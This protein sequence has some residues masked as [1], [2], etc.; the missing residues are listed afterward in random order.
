M[1]AI[2]TCDACPVGDD[3]CRGIR[4]RRDCHNVATGVGGYAAMLRTLAG[5]TTPSTYLFTGGM[6]DLIVLESWMSAAARAR[7]RTALWAAPNSPAIAAMLSSIPELAHVEHVHLWSEFSATGRRAFYSMADLMSVVNDPRLAD[8]EDWSTSARFPKIRAGEYRWGGS[9][10]LKRPGP[11][12]A[13]FGLPDR[14]VAICPETTSTHRLDRWFTDADWGWVL[15]YLERTGEVGVVLNGHG[16]LRPPDHPNLIDLG[17][18]TTFLESVEVVRRCDGYLGIDSALSVIAAEVL[19]PW[20]LA[21]K[22]TVDFMHW[23]R[24]VCYPR[25]AGYVVVRPRMAAFGA[26]PRDPLAS[27]RWE[28]GADARLEYCPA[29]GVA[30]L[31]DA[32]IDPAVYDDRYLNKYI[33]MG[34]SPIGVA[35]NEFRVAL[36]AKYAGPKGDVLD[37]GIGCGTFLDRLGDRPKWGYDVNPAGIAWL[38]ERG[39]WHD[40]HDGLPECCRVV[41]FHDALEHF[42]W[43]GELLATFPD[44]VHVIVTIPIFPDLARIVESKHWRPENGEHQLYFT[45]SGLIGYMTDLGY[46]AVEVRDD[47]TRIGREDIL[48]GAFRKGTKPRVALGAPHR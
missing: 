37:V 9:S 47:E 15:A 5:V 18:G 32:R 14:Y 12:V 26:W 42:R 44:G 22:S 35:L 21:V 45:E 8:A 11:D 19:P 6:G 40:P 36:T 2:G 3:R 48:T 24:D 23:W 25:A 7:L 13:R 1:T 31:R 16:A 10:L 28:A 27:Y 39:L 29:R 46:E 34:S 17:G 30:R 20:R 4:H 41:T 33:Q 38:R 43:P